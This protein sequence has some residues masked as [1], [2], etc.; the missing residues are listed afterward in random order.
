MINKKEEYSFSLNPEDDNSL[1]V[2]LRGA[3][4][5]E[6]EETPLERPKPRILYE[7]KE[8]PREIPKSI[9]KSSFRREVKETEKVEKPAEKVIIHEKK[10]NGAK[11]PPKRETSSWKKIRVLF[12]LFLLTGGLIF[13]FVYANPS[14]TLNVG[15]GKTSSLA[16]FSEKVDYETSGNSSFI[17][18]LDYSKF[19]Q[20]GKEASIGITGLVAGNGRVKVFLVDENDKKAKEHVL[21]DNQVE[22]SEKLFM[23]GGV[24]GTAGMNNEKTGKETEDT[25]EISKFEYACVDTCYSKFKEGRYVVRVETDSTAIRIDKVIL[26][27]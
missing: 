25:S 15:G 21:Y 10:E 27:F 13:L 24:T 7:K 12:T 14:I 4:E 17:L 20:Q 2:Y 5:E 18:D 8:R 11:N 1:S 23:M 16:T 3:D 22:K 26:G 9:P 6:A 19:N